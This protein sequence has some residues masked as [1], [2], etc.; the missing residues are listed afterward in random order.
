MVTEKLF[1]LLNV[2][3]PA[4]KWSV[5]ILFQYIYTLNEPM[6]RKAAYQRKTHNES[7]KMNIKTCEQEKN[8]NKNVERH[9]CGKA[10]S[11]ADPRVHSCVSNGTLG[12]LS[13][14]KGGQ[15]E[16]GPVASG[17]LSILQQNQHYYQ[18]PFAQAPP[19]KHHRHAPVS[20]MRTLTAG[21]LSGM[22]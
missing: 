11:G 19:S 21:S 9:Q 4:V 8:I 1:T 22:T 20:P 17:R 5:A 7:I 16:L 10:P 13:T 6:F 2:F 12:F 3:I 18:P 14:T 15:G